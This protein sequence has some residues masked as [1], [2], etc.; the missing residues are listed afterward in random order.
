[1]QDFRQTPVADI[2]SPKGANKFSASG[3][4]GD[5]D[6]RL[7][8]LPKTA[9][10]PTTYAG[11]RSHA[12]P[13]AFSTDF[14]VPPP[15][16]VQNQQ[17]TDDRNPVAAA[18]ATDETESSKD[19]LG[20]IA[21]TS[22]S[23]GKASVTPFGTTGNIPGL[24]PPRETES[25]DHVEIVS[26]TERQTP[27]GAKSKCVERSF[28]LFYFYHFFDDFQIRSDC[29]LQICPF[30]SLIIVRKSD[31]QSKTEIYQSYE[32]CD[33]LICSCK[34]KPVITSKC[35]T[36]FVSAT[37]S[38]CFNC[39]TTKFPSF[40]AFPLLERFYVSARCI[41]SRCLSMC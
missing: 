2:P 41:F 33:K 39:S 32:L 38:T 24:T 10:S 31:F 36:N 21:S 8:P 40:L 7:P 4:V 3:T 18:V 14:S 25:P 15:P 29:G 20:R 12:L 5:S 22:E 28:F 6:Y 1:M 11:N 16:P 37:F 26:V 23:S 13:Q 34:V 17:D 27:A 35:I 30:L 19:F 9:P